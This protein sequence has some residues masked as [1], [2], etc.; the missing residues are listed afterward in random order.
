MRQIIDCQICCIF[1]I[2]YSIEPTAK[3]KFYPNPI[4]NKIAII[5]IYSHIHSH[6]IMLA[7]SSALENVASVAGRA[8]FPGSGIS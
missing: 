6:Q 8:G 2:D 1:S 7:F 3:T 5:S 4:F